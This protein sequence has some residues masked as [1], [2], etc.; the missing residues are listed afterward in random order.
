MYIKHDDD[1]DDVHSVAYVHRYSLSLYKNNLVISFSVWLSF[2]LFLVFISSLLFI[3]R[4]LLERA[5]NLFHYVF[6]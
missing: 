1:Y 4:I 3:I 5:Q 2:F 6:H